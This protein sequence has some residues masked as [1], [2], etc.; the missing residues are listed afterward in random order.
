MTLEYI[1]LEDQF[2]E[3]QG[4]VSF[5]LLMKKGVYIVTMLTKYVDRLLMILL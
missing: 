2:I 1:E 3:L 4:A 5:L